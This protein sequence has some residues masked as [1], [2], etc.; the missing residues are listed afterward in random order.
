MTGGNTNHYTTADLAT[1]EKL[2]YQCVTTMFTH[3]FSLRETY[4]VR[5]RSITHDLVD[6]ADLTYNK[7]A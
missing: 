5:R 2:D 4:L 3:D 6:R 1:E 7:L